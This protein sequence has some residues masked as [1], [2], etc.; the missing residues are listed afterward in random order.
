LP[1]CVDA[2]EQNALSPRVSSI[3]GGG[4]AERNRRRVDGSSTDFDLGLHRLALAADG[5]GSGD[6]SNAG[7][8]LGGGME[9]RAP[10]LPPKGGLPPNSSIFI[11]RSPYDK[12]RVVGHQIGLKW[13][14]GVYLEFSVFTCRYFGISL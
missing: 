1:K 11:S 12:L 2:T 7:P 6:Y 8:D 9:P 13:N 14:L 3:C 4:G 5:G 10:G